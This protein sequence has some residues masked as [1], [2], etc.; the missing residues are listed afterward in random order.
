MQGARP[1]TIM[2]VIAVAMAVTSASP[3]AAAAGKLD[4]TFSNDGRVTAFPNG[5]SGY[6]AVIDQKG[7]IV[8]AGHTLEPDADFTVTRFRS[9][10]TP[11]ADFGGGDGRVT[12]DLGGGDFAFDLALGE[13]GRI[14]VAGRRERASGSVMAVAA[15]GPRGGL[16]KKF[17][18]DGLAFVNFGKAFQG[19][20]AVA[21]SANDK[22]VL[23]G[24]TSNGET[25][26]WALARLKPNGGRDRAFGGDGRVTVDLSPADEQVND[27][28]IVAGGRI[29]AVGS[30]ASGLSPRI[31]LG[32]FL[33]GGGLDRDFGNRGVRITNVAQ[34]A[35][36]G[37]GLAQQPDEKLVVAAQVANGG[38]GDWGVLRYGANGRL[39]DTFSGDGIRILS[40]GPEF[41]LARSVAVQPNGRIVVVGRVRRNDDDRFGVVRLR[42]N[43]SYD[44][45]FSKDGRA[46]VGF[47]G[48]A[49]TARGVVLQENGKI[50][51]AGE[52]TD[53]GTRRFAVARLLGS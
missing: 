3:A 9:N 32:W 1:R 7:R 34:G 4:R 20:N 35:D 53:R 36:I 6:A 33:I 23:G 40:F 22:I 46:A 18:K 37:Y 14:V 50:V 42:L 38:N 51:V 10:G 27:L 52:A 24:S 17:S 44:R 49:N 25:S 31:A 5:A 48:G 28:V 30:A 47:G 11:D 15:L 13:G 45:N 2:A 29:V 12:I 43:G 21:V 19:A 39:D 26:R 41:E 8:V 16:D